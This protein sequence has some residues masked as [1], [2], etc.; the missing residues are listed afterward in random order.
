MYVWVYVLL[1]MCVVLHVCM[2]LCIIM[3]VVLHVCNGLC[4]IIYVCTIHCKYYMYMYMCTIIMYIVYVC[5]CMYGVG[6]KCML[7]KK[8]CRVFIVCKK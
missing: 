2:G 7:L 3:C 8:S 5:T 1:C 4:I 6:A